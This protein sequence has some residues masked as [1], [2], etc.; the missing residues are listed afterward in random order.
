MNCN[1][2]KYYRI[3]GPAT[4]PPPNPPHRAIVVRKRGAGRRYVCGLE[5]PVKITME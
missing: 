3:F 1:Y 4:L 5:L 2:N